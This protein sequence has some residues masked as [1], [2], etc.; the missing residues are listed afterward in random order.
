LSVKQHKIDDG[1]FPLP[2]IFLITALRRWRFFITTVL[3]K[4]ISFAII[5]N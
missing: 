4:I 5:I 3:A 2:G 1:A